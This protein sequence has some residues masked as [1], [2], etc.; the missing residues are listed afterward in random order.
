MLSAHIYNSWVQHSIA[1]I[2][3][4]SFWR[5]FNEHTRCYKNKTT[6]TTESEFK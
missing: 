3:K 6:G 4:L 5:F 2:H 1:T